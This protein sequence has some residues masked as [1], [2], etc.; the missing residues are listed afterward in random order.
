MMEAF[1]VLNK[2][3]RWLLKHYQ[4]IFKKCGCEILTYTTKDTM[5]VHQPKLIESVKEYKTPASPRTRIKS[6]DKE[7]ILISPEMQ[8]QFWYVVILGKTFTF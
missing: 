2:I 3:S 6:P 5:Y 4:T 1:L 8:T 7:D